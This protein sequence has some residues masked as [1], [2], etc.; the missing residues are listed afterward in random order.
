MALARKNY[1]TRSEKTI[2]LIIGFDLWWGLLILI[3]VI[4]IAVLSALNAA[5]I[6]PDVLDFSS[7]SGTDAVFT[8]IQL[9]VWCLPLLFNVGLLVFFGLTR[10]WIALGMLAAFAIALCLVVL[11]GVLATAAC[12]VLI[13]GGGAGF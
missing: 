13:G 2:D 12:F 8:V 9:A 7:T 4:R 3:W 10:Y 6:S 11:A 1:A 5:G